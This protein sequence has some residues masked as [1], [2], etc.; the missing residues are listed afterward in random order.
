MIF[1]HSKAIS[2]NV[3]TTFHH[4]K[5]ISGD[6]ETTFQRSKFISTFPEANLQHLMGIS[7]FP[8]IFSKKINSFIRLLKIF[9]YLAKRLTNFQINK[10]MGN[11]TKIKHIMLYDL[12]NTEYLAYLNALLELLPPPPPL[13]DDRPVIESV[14]DEVLAQGSPDIGLSAE[15]VQ[16]LE[17]DV[18]LLAD[19]VNE[20]R[21]SQE[22]EEAGIHETN[23]DNLVLYITSRISRA[24]TLPL[25]VERNA[26][27]HLYKVVKPYIGIA[28]LPFA[29]ET[30]QIKGMLIDLRKEENAAYVTALGLDTYL[31]ELEKEN[32]A[33]AALTS[34]RTQSRA[35]NKKESGTELR[36]RL[37]EQY[38][39]LVMLAQSFSV[40]KPSEAATTFVKN[41]NQ[42]ISETVTAYNQRK[43][44]S[45]SKPTPTPPADDRPVIAQA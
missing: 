36:K 11:Y 1:H 27:K 41:L 39:D 30:E 45:G 29:Q 35:A 42:L 16:T 4:S 8:E 17:N 32:N 23:R 25:E 43:K 28:R 31:T 40:A 22:T 24:G 9:L 6:V 14:N 2:G 20:S 26:G 19:V 38:D 10:I 15:F 34:K 5:A 33:Y 7:G 44:G 18:M 12:N 3:E 21:I 13:P 37:D